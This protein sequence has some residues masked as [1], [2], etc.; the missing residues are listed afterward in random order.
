MDDRTSALVAL[1]AS[2]ARGSRGEWRDHMTRALQSCAATE[3]EEAI[4]QSCLFLGYPTTLQALAV[5]R[6]V[7]QEPVSV[8]SPVNV[9]T[10][11]ERGQE[12]CAAV[13][14]GQY[15]RL[16]AN[17]VRLHPDVEQWMLL[18][19]YGKII[20]RP[21]FDLKTREL[22]IIALLASQEAPHQLY[23]HLRGA[24]QTGSSLAEVDEVVMSVVRALPT[25]RAQQARQLW[26]ELRARKLKGD[27]EGDGEER[28]E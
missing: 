12:V 19:G 15:E 8:E 17:V 20:G 5:W 9:E 28:L 7:T 3:I 26:S 1:S 18:E 11:R 16:R 4:L 2:L 6:E 23:S 14:G 27:G 21:G 13:Y 25:D 22:C 10:W 24:L